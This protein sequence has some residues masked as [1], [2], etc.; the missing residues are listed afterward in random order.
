MKRSTP[1]QIHGRKGR[2]TMKFSACELQVLSITVILYKDRQE[3]VL[4]QFFFVNGL[5]TRA[6]YLYCIVNLLNAR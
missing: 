1:L 5:L 4:M 3:T 6:G 2:Q